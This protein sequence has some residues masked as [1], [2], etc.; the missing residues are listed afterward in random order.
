LAVALS[1][2]ILLCFNFH[3]LQLPTKL[4]M[5]AP[6]PHIV[7]LST[8]NLNPDPNADLWPFKSLAHRV[9]PA[10]ANIHT[11]FGFC[12]PYSFRQNWVLQ[13]KQFCL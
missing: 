1:A 11:N 5:S 13:H 10:L 2:I 4:D 7:Q 6:C 9:T 12:A 3:L 8:Y